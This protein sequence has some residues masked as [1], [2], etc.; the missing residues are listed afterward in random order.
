MEVAAGQAFVRISK[1]YVSGGC[2]IRSNSKGCPD[3]TSHPTSPHLIVVKAIVAAHRR[4]GRSASSDR[5]GA[6]FTSRLHPVS[7]H[8]PDTAPTN[9]L[10]K[11]LEA[12]KN[13]REAL[14]TLELL[15]HTCQ[16]SI[17]TEPLRD[18]HVALFVDGKAETFSGTAASKFSGL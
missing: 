2:G 8:E 5:H 17:A 15:L 6:V 1:A 13:K 18:P 14:E 3:S 9:N 10:T 12:K 7:V 4:A 16:L 11:D